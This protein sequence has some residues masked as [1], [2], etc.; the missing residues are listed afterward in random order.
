MRETFAK[1]VPP[2]SK[3]AQVH[4]KRNEL[5]EQMRQDGVEFTDA[6]FQYLHKQIW[7]AEWVKGDH[8][9]EDESDSQDVPR[10]ILPRLRS[11][12]PRLRLKYAKYL[13]LFQNPEQGAWSRVPLIHAMKRDGFEYDSTEI[14][15]LRQ[16]VHYKSWRESQKNA[17]TAS[18]VSE[19]VLTP[20]HQH[21]SGTGEAEADPG[22]HRP[23]DPVSLQS[24][25]QA[26]QLP[27]SPAGI[28]G[29]SLE[30]S[31]SSSHRFSAGLSNTVTSEG[32][33]SSW[34]GKFQKYLPLFAT[35]P[36]GKWTRKEVV[37]AI[38]KDGLEIDA[39]DVR[40]I[41]ETIALRERKAAAAPVLRM[42]WKELQKKY[43]RYIPANIPE[44]KELTLRF[45]VEQMEKDGF[46]FDLDE[47]RR[48]VL[49]LQKRILRHKATHNFGQEIDGAESGDP[50]EDAT[51][52]S[53]RPRMLEEPEDTELDAAEEPKDVE[54]GAT[55]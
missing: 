37:E 6:E 38:E 48:L 42:P 20:E 54:D 7:R 2:G 47:V 26:Y 29:P 31:T 8:E 52:R 27:N 32:L 13:P 28:T 24:L 41:R 50:N 45:V 55:D 40:R 53:K 44:V 4:M 22:C 35:P 30:A 5:I 12:L 18:S 17:A 1:Y 21:S 23:K 10:S 25:N 14:R 43:S 3:W 34:L 9:D 19:A 51:D 46:E 33:A 15:A 11:I 16:S 49:T 39:D 36:N